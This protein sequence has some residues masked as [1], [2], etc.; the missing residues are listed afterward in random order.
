MRPI[1]YKLYFLGLCLSS[2][3]FSQD[4]PEVVQTPMTD[5]LTKFYVYDYVNM[6][7]FHGDEGTL[8]IDAGFQETGEQVKALLKKKGIQPVRYLVNT[9]S[10]GDHT[11]GNAILGQ[12]ATILS[13]PDCLAK[14]SQRD[15]FHRQGLPQV[16]FTDPV[17]IH[18]NG[19]RIH[20]I[21][22]SAGHSTEDVLVHFE[23]ANV[24]VIGDIIVGDSFP[25][26]RAH[27]GSSVQALLK[28]IQFILDNF[29]EDINIALSHGRDYAK[30]DL[31]EYQKM[32]TETIDI[33][34]NA[35][36]EGKTPQQMKEKNILAKWTDW[37]NK[38]WTW[39][40]TDLWI[41][42]VCAS[43]SLDN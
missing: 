40:N 27:E 7:V 43:Y 10:D 39:I 35:H 5:N 21:P 25:F 3:L 20:L 1:R 26:V 6:F 22:L 19:E 17:I 37:N 18:M 30:A 23:K 13:H 32:L 38:K 9:H 15:D 2:S 33:I 28:N 42:T 36:Q 12:G 24:L 29:Q 31:R 16:T 4:L 41:D 34:R 14:L 8:L 11:G